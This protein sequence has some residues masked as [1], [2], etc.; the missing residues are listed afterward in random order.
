MMEPCNQR[1]NSLEVFLFAELNMKGIHRSS[2]TNIYFY[3]KYI[4]QSSRLIDCLV[5]KIPE[6]SE[7]V[8]KLLFLFVFWYTLRSLC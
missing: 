8:T 2:A 6:N 5:H 3:C 4:C 1:N 7:N